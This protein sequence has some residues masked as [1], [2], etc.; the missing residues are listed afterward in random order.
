MKSKV[1]L[2][3]PIYS[4]LPYKEVNVPYRDKN[5]IRRVL[6]FD[7][8]EVY[9]RVTINPFTRHQRCSDVNTT[10]LFPKLFGVCSCG[11]GKLLIGKRTKWASGVC[12]TFA[13]YVSQVIS[14]HVL[15]IKRLVLTYHDYKCARC[16]NSDNIQIDHII[17]VY[18]GGGGCWLNNYQPLC[19]KCHKI[20]T[21]NDYEIY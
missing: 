6:V 2:P 16:G 8:Y 3:K 1:I 17:P 9:D 11:C 10:A 5:I 19:T 21:R 7:P 15:Y 18:A 12:H 13:H 20:K 14:G 4:V